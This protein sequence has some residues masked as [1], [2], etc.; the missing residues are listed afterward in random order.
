ML[1]SCC[2]RIKRLL[3]VS[4]STAWSKV[5]S[6]VCE[7]T[8]RQLNIFEDDFLV[9]NS[10]CDMRWVMNS[11]ADMK[12]LTTPETCVYYGG[13]LNSET[14]FLIL[15][16]SRWLLPKSGKSIHLLCW[17][18]ADINRQRERRGETTRSAQM[19]EKRNQTWGKKT[20]SVVIFSHTAVCVERQQQRKERFQSGGIPMWERGS[21]RKATC[22]K[23]E[24]MLFNCNLRCVSFPGTVTLSP[25][26]SPQ[27]EISVCMCVVEALH[28]RGA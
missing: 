13:L 27:V 25:M 15:I 19:G 21:E 20:K 9:E 26:T 14:C 3:S 6:K 18:H 12:T 17:V 23:C 16:S 5:V 8:V 7:A 4:S 1:C 24:L 10:P 22:F 2:F 28:D 11:C